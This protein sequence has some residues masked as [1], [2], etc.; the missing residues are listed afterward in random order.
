[1]IWNNHP[2]QDRDSS[3]CLMGKREPKGIPKGSGTSCSLEINGILFISFWWKCS[4]FANQDFSICR[5]QSF[6]DE[7]HN[8]PK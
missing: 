1:M 4:R 8:F 3:S 6:R 2:C 7:K 5:S